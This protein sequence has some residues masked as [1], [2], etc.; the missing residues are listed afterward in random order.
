MKK[1]FAPG[2]NREEVPLVS[3]K[4]DGNRFEGEFC[5][6]LAKHGFWVHN[7]AQNAH[8][9]PADVIA[10]KNDKVFL[11]DCKF[12]TGKYFSLARIEENQESAMMLWQECGNGDGWFAV[13][14]ERTIWMVPLWRLQIEQRAQLDYTWFLTFAI[15]FEVWVGRYGEWT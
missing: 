9:Q 7:L 12:C 1:H 10:A 14:I 13:S 3:N 4:S 11:I 2:V 15:R 5:E 8:G 6:L